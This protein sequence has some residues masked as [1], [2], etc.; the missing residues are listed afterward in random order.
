M[1][2][3]MMMTMM[4]HAFAKRGGGLFGGGGLSAT[5]AEQARALISLVSPPAPATLTHFS[6]PPTN[7][8]LACDLK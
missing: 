7:S 4:S 3:L 1:M 6:P 5:A 8:R 2:W